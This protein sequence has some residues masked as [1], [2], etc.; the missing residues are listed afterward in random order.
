VVLCAVVSLVTFS[1]LSY[2]VLAPLAYLMATLI[3]GQF[4]TPVLLGRRLNLN[5]VAVFAAVVLWAWV[6]GVAGAL[7]AVPLLVCLKSLCDH[8]PALSVL[9]T[10]LGDSS[11]PAARPP[12]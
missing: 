8:V 9:G 2:A 10:F 1:A 11:A 12:A 5:A 4:V 6:W 3:E 7:M